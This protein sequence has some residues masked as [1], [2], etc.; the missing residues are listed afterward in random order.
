MFLLPLALSLIGL[1]VGPS[2]ARSLNNCPHRGKVWGAFLLPLFALVS[3]ALSFQA[4][5]ASLAGAVSSGLTAH[6]SFSSSLAA[7]LICGA[8]VACLLNSNSL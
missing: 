4:L 6:R 7:T 1:A 3:P 5:G 2:V 8:S